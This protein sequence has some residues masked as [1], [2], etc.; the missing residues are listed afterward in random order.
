MRFATKVKFWLPSLQIIAN[1]A[2]PHSDV[3]PEEVLMGC[4]R[5]LSAAIGLFGLAASMPVAALAQ[6]AA[7]STE[8]P[9]GAKLF[10]RQCGTCHSL[11][12]GE[13]RQ[14][15]NL[16]GVYGRHAGTLPDYK[17]SAGFAAADWSWDAEHL[18]PYLTN[19]QAVI[20]GGVMGYRQANPAIRSAIIDY[21]KDPK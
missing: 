4:I 2:Q 9:D 12:P 20:E 1:I 8:A 17:Y 18:D 15:P 16:A 7:P 5:A 10:G 6:F 13:V 19:P 11:V 3:A 14:G 21:L